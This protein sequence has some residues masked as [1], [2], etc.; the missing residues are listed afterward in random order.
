MDRTGNDAAQAG[1]PGPRIRIL[2]DDVQTVTREGTS[3]LGASL[4]AGIKHCHECGGNARCSTCRVVIIDGLDRCGARN[5]KEQAI[6]DR[7]LFPPEVRLA[8]QT[9]VGGDLVVRRLVLDDFDVELTSL[10]RDGVR[11]WPVGREQSVALMFLDI[12]GFTSFSESL[13]PYDVIHLLRR[14]FLRMAMIVE[15]HRGVVD[16]YMGDGMLAIF[17]AEDAGAA[18]LHA[19]RAGQAMLGEIEIM[20]PYVHA[21][22]GKSFDIGVGVHYG[23]VVVGALGGPGPSAPK[24]TVIGDAV[25][26]ASRVESANKVTG[27]RFLIS[28]AAY[29]ELRG[30]VPVGRTF[31]LP[32]P[33]KAGVHALYEVEPA[34]ADGD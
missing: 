16:N 20:K 24:V 31:H 22:A 10:V 23:Q 30:G 13:L 27:T 25:N 6:A 3:I 7:L 17:G 1:T 5:E 34:D 26:M 18:T 9:R 11:A 2:P 28:D 29:R 14:F 33:G 21:V 4:G 12:R 32:L 19:V 8:C 15:E